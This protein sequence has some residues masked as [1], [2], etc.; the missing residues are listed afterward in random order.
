LEKAIPKR[1]A[2]FVSGIQIQDNSGERITSMSLYLA[3]LGHHAVA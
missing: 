1:V 3:H 2:F